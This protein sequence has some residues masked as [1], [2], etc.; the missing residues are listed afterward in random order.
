MKDLKVI[1]YEK[2]NEWIEKT[3]KDVKDE[4]E[5]IKTNEDEILDRFYKDLEFGTG[6]MRGKMGAGSNRMNIYTVARATQGFANYIKSKKDFP[7]VVIAY[8]NRNMSPKFSKIAAQVFA[9]NGIRVY[10]FP[11]LTATPILSYAVRH[12]SADGGI[13]ITAS[14]NPPEYNGYKVYTSD[15]T[16]AVPKY[17]KMI[18]EEVNKLD[19]FN[20]IK[21][22]NYDEAVEQEKIKILDD[23]LFNDYI[24]EIEGYIR[25]IDPSIKRNLDITYTPLHGTGLKPVEEILS[26]L[27]FNVNIVKEQA[28]HDGNFPTVKSPNPEEKKAF[29]MALKLAKET[30]SELVLATDPDADRIGV[31]EKNGNDY[32]T[33]NGNEMG[34]MLSHF[35][36]TN[37][38]EHAILPKNGVIIKTIVSTEMIKPIAKEFGIE[39]EETLTGFK[40]IGEKMEYYDQTKTKKFLF[41][42]EESYGCLANNHARDKD[43][44]IASALIATLKSKLKQEKKTLKEYL[45]ELN[46]KYGFYKEKLL[47]YTFEGI[48]G[49]QKISKLMKIIKEEPPAKLNNAELFETVDYNSGINGLPKSNVIELRYE[50]IKIIARPSG[51]EPKIKFY[52]MVKGSSF[53]EAMSKIDFA[54]KAVSEIVNKI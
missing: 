42:F 45:Q 44:V 36:L 24:D 16:Q 25:S 2:L 50:N 23:E 49:N 3:E 11:E 43:A 15:G 28:I 39:V 5:K 30:N 31:F 20:D 27:G 1:S 8:D 54:E 4:L 46:E 12:L 29:D 18:I 26:K 51:T 52:L 38:K 17:A 32:V 47:S 48:Q 14:H 37:M 33:F 9:G 53:E 40:F 10:L 21:I 35:L 22:M 41:G 6:G 13:V 7:S 34:I 19:Y